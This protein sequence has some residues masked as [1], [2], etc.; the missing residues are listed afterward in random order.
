METE[1]VDVIV[2]GA[3][4]AG[5]GA[6]VH[7]KKHCPEKRYVI[8][9]SREAM[10]GT[11]DLFRYPGIRSDSD[12]HTLGYNFKPWI[13]EKAIAEGPA[14]L[15][16]I[17]ETADEYG[18][19][20]HIRYKHK[21]QSAS[22]DS[23]AALWTLQVED[24]DGQ[25]KTLSSQFL[26][27]C[28][29]YYRYEKGY[30]PAFAGREDFQGDILH[31]QQW[32]EDF[33]YSGKRVV[34]IGSGA[35]AV[36]LVP[37]MADKASHVVMLQR[38]PTYLV[39]RPFK[40]SFANFLRKVLPDSWAYGLTRW[41]NTLFQH[42]IYRRSRSHP[43]HLRKKLLDRVRKEMG[44]NYDVDTHFK[45]NYNPWDQRLCLVPDSDFFASLRSGKSSVVTDQIE[46]FTANGILL[47]SGQ[48][49]EADVIVTATGLDMSLMGDI[50][51]AVDDKPI[52]FAETW[53]Y[54]GL[55][56]SGVPNL[57]NTFGYINAS[58]TLRSDITAEYFC[59]MIKEADAQGKR[60]VTPNLRDIDKTME[61]Y[62]WIKEFSSG[63]MQRVMHLFPKQAEQ[64][65]WRNTQNYLKDRKDFKRDRFNDGALTFSNP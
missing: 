30:T 54:K 55:M 32:P 27:T 58:Y 15:D 26:L 62:P 29:G 52:N 9:E 5:I 6:G 49:L 18:I 64:S 28:A 1:Q 39:S 45:P 42:Y 53:T 61:P 22:W 25:T 12:M 8:L 34:V 51:F 59:R 41:R 16:Y 56:Y 31:P 24:G 10:G 17:H 63:Y 48:E 40:D 13:A 4:L 14:I 35:T 19:H 20:E 3:G 21:V 60:Q 43:R 47:K 33:D 7:L 65:P 50:T 38:S 11:W 23:N 44:P 2:V 46:R 36:T 37:A 57:V